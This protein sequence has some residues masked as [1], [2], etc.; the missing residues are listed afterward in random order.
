MVIPRKKANGK[1]RWLQSVEKPGCRL[2]RNRVSRQTGT[3]FYKLVN[4]T[5]TTKLRTHFRKTHFLSFGQQ[6]KSD[7]TRKGHRR[8]K[9][10]S[11]FAL[12]RRTEH[13]SC[14]S[15]PL[16]S[17][18]TNKNV[19]FSRCTIFEDFSLVFRKEKRRCTNFVQSRSEGIKKSGKS[20]SHKF[21]FFNF[22]FIAVGTGSEGKFP[23]CFPLLDKE[24]KRILLRFLSKRLILD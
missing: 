20:A 15:F 1:F 8:K 14:S 3:S 9:R 19:P 16:G 12:Q 2:M 18:I 6:E 7:G 22:H 4:M 17:L 5:E 10:G 13:L 21:H 24:R 11:G 23:P